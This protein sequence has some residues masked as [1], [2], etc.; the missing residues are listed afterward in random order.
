MSTITSISGQRVIFSDSSSLEVP[1]ELTPMHNGSDITLKL[2]ISRREFRFDLDVTKRH[3]INSINV[4]M[5]DSWRLSGKEGKPRL[6][7]LEST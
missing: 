6:V 1:W 4:L 3:F 2:D 5:V 7:P